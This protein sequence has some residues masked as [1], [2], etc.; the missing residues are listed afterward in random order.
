VAHVLIAALVALL[1]AILAGPFFID[2]LRRHSLGQNIREEGPQ[3]HS[4]KQGTPTMGGILIVLAAGV[5]F[6]ATTVGTLSALTI[7]GTMVA[8]GAIGFV[9]DYMK[10]RHKRSLGLSGRVK[11]LLLLAISAV[12]CYAAHH[13]QLHHSVFVPIVQWTIPLSWWGYYILIFLIIAGSA[14]AVNLTDGID[15]LAAGAAI[16]SLFTLTAMAVIIYIRNAPGGVRIANRLDVAYIGAALIGAAVGFLWFNAFP[17]EVFMGDTGSMALGGAIG[18]M[19]I[20]LQVP[21]LLLLVG[22]IFVIEALSVVIQVI[23]FRRFGKRVFLM[24]PIHHHFEMKSWSETKIMVRF[25]I[26]TGIL[27]TGGFAL[28]YKYYPQIRP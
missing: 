20:F 28:F 15:G 7:F 27:C 5:A 4:V 24:A 10:V 17:A 11:M 21:L 6:L 16:I 18:A 8:C 9:D 14:N 19:A 26:V 13:Q 1:I 22:G 25:W 12:V 3:H 2:F 23:S